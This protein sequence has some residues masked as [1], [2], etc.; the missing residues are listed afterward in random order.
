LLVGKGRDGHESGMPA[1]LFAKTPEPPYYAVITSQQQANR[2][3]GYD[4]MAGRMV[5]LARAQ[6]GFL[7][8]ESVR[9]ANGF[10]LTV[11]YWASEEAIARWKGHL[12]HQSAQ[13]AGKRLW[14]ADHQLRVA[15]V[16]RAYGKGSSSLGATREIRVDDLKGPE[17]AALL[18]HHLR[19][20][21]SISP[22]ESCHA[23]TLEELRR[24]GVTFWCVWSGGELAGCG[25]LKEVDSTHA[26]IK[27]M[28]TAPGHLRKGV[29]AGLLEHLIEEA[30]RRGYRRLSLETGA[31]DHFV[32]ARNL[33]RKFGFAECG[34][35]GGYVED[36]NSVFMTKEI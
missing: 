26:E 1:D 25:A 3:A 10:G 4:Q 21:A 22:R 8:V 33:Y 15:K 18:E 35:F 14:Y 7:G 19:E 12:E 27:S 13:E 20:L 24:P 5:E 32:P 23:M 29:A 6:P 34:P 28:R 17:I 31:N 9:G 11:S 16:E 36:P 30:I 2:D